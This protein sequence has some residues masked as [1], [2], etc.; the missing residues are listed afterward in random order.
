[1]VFVIQSEIY[2]F[3]ACLG[4][5][6]LNFSLCKWDVNSLSKLLLLLE[7]KSRWLLKQFIPHSSR[8][9]LWRCLSSL[10]R[11]EGSLGSSFA[12]SL[13]MP[14]VC[15]LRFYSWQSVLKKMRDRIQRWG[16]NDVSHRRQTGLCNSQSAGKIQPSGTI[17]P[18]AA[19]FLPACCQKKDHVSCDQN[20]STPTE[21]H[22]VNS[23]PKLVILNGGKILSRTAIFLFQRR[24][25]ELGV[26]YL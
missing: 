10:L 9:A 20:A 1:M 18:A 23:F 7:K 8:I 11:T 26:H 14:N 21:I 2:I 5:I 4:L 24:C 19:V 3:W 13:E 15:E 12:E 22:L 17:N 25:L 6:T 16:D